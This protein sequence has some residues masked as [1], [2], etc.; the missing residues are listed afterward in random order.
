MSWR[1]PV[2]E[3]VFTDSHI[4]EL[5][6]R[7]HTQAPKAKAFDTPFRYSDSGGCV[8]QLAY[9]ALGIEPDDDTS[10][11]GLAVMDLGTM[12]HE[13]LQEAIG[14]RYPDAEFE[15]PTQIDGLISGHCDAVAVIDGERTLFEFKTQGAY[16]FDKAIGLNRKGRKL[17]SPSGPNT[18]YIIQAGLNALALGCTQVVI[19]YFSKEAVSAPLAADT[20]MRP[21]DR[22]VAEWNVPRDVWEP[23]ATAE[24]DRLFS[25]TEGLDAGLL[26]PRY[27]IDDDGST[28]EADPGAKYAYW[29]CRGYCGYRARCE[30]DGPGV[31]PVPVE[32]RA[33]EAS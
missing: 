17:G 4:R 33:R 30:A 11:S 12:A 28:A 27:Y 29:R 20:G 10:A 7:H 24:L 16:A 2:I 26:P 21:L 15:V 22:I 25:V 8:R 13:A 31:V 23:L 19:G 3:P 18:S 32:I 6:V 5:I 9:K 14:R 1:Q